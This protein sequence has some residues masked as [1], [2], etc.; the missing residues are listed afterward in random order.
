VLALSVLLLWTS[1]WAAK[2]QAID[3]SI[4]IDPNSPIGAVNRAVLGN[5]ALAYLNFNTRLSAEGA[6][7][8]DPKS[9]APVAAM[10]RLARDIGLPTLRWPGGCAVHEYDWKLAVGPLAKRPQQPFGL[11]EF[12]KLAH[13]IGA[14]PV[15][16]IADYWGEPKDAADLVE[17]LNGPAGKNENGGVDWSAV[18][19]ADGHPEPY[20]VVWFEYGN[21]TSHGTH[22]AG[23]QPTGN[24][25][26]YSA[27][28]YARRYLAYRAA[29]KAVDP[30][31]RLGAVLDND[32]QPSLSPWTRTIVRETGQTADFYIEHAYLPQYTRTDGSPDASDL[33]RLA[34]A[35]PPQLRAVFSALSEFIRKSAGHPI[36]LAVTEYNASFVQDKP[37]PYRLSLGAAIEVA[38]MVQVLLDPSLNVATAQYWHFA[39]EYWGMVKGFNAPYTLRPAYHVFQ[40]YHD[41]LGDTL[42]RTR[43]K[44]PAYQEPGGFG[45]VPAHGDGSEF[46]LLGPAVALDGKW[47]IGSSNGAKAEKLPDGGLR[48]TISTRNELD[49]YQSGVTIPAR[50]STGYR[51]TAE[52]RTKGLSRR[53]VQLQIGDARGWTATKSAALSDMVSGDNWSEASVD[54]VTLPDAR[55]IQIVVRRRAGTPEPGQFEVR[56]LRVQ[57]FRP[58]VLPEIPYIGAIATRKGDRVSAFIVNRR[59]DGPVRLRIDADGARDARGWTLGGP[60]IDATNEARSDNVKVGSLEVQPQ[61]DV[62]SAM[63]PAHSFSVIEF[64]VASANAA[65]LP[66]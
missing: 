32:I 58:F 28:E 47:S 2:E 46:Q 13:E 26:R 51:V 21:E 61:H 25:R 48:V 60:S 15:I 53:G 20:G 31:I 1:S 41:H 33:F 24:S 30:G 55:A 54:Y 62:L 63:L 45:V 14:V 16:T 37:T 22:P 35:G 29:M 5:N 9:S 44:S 56:N 19:A 4:T 39:N 64:D 12:L 17:Y 38:D 40:L 43:V 49:Y 59:V 42:V 18:R 65:R 36:L 6:G 27:D 52:I 10:V 11:P 34:F 7:M 66:R 23:T 50:A 3:A 8:W 57:R